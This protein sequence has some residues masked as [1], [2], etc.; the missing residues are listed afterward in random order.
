M[1]LK[2]WHRGRVRKRKIRFPCFF[3]FYRKSLE[4]EANYHS[5]LKHYIKNTF[6]F[7]LI[8]SLF[9][10]SEHYAT[11]MNLG[12]SKEIAV[13]LTLSSNYSYLH[14]HSGTV[15]WAF[16]QS[17]SYNSNF[18][19]RSLQIKFKKIFDLFIAPP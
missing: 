6:F 19:V 7:C 14:F 4:K 5:I 2:K 15:S 10:S 17:F 9:C 1:S 13:I 16:F 18:H 12:M 8:V 3:I 11:E